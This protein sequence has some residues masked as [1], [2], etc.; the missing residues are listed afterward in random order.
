MGTVVQARMPT[1]ND[2]A[3]TPLLSARLREYGVFPSAISDIAAMLVSSSAGLSIYSFFL[4][5]GASPMG[6]SRECKW[7][8]CK[9]NDEQ[10][11]RRH[12]LAQRRI[13]CDFFPPSRHNR[14]LGRDWLGLFFWA[15]F[16][17]RDNDYRYYRKSD[18][19]YLRAYRASLPHLRDAS[20]LVRDPLQQ[21]LLSSQ[22][23]QP[24]YRPYQ[25]AYLQ[26]N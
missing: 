19:K 12:R 17:R 25:S 15:R 3:P 26:Y 14:D 23:Q 1:G 21:F 7:P 5:R 20:Q 24:N 11:E 13:S 22:H 10:Q 4:K 8:A 9:R 2:V 16:L 6:C 18:Q